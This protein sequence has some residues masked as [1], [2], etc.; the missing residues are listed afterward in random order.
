ME[1]LW[2]YMFTKELQVSA[3]EHPL[4]L[5]EPLYHNLITLTYESRPKTHREKL[6]EIMFEKFN[7]PALFLANQSLL[8]LFATGRTTGIVVRINLCFLIN[9]QGR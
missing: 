7:V 9:F 2:E 1:L 3:D 5:T 6:T 8:A 4:L